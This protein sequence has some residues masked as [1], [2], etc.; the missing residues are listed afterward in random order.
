[1][2]LSAEQLGSMV[3]HILEKGYHQPF[4]DGKANREKIEEE[5]TIGL[6][7]GVI[8]PVNQDDVDWI[9]DLVDTLI[10]EYGDRDE[11]KSK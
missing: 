4:V 11:G 6:Y 1:M 3:F 10:S 9:C 5:I 2:L 7:K 8:P